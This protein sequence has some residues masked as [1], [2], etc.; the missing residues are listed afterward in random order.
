[1]RKKELEVLLSNVDGFINPK[2]KFEQYLTSSSIVADIIWDAYQKGYIEGKVVADLGC[3]SGI[4][5]F[6]ALLLGAKKVFFV[7][8]DPDAIIIAKRNKIFL[9][10]KLKKNFSCD[11]FCCSVQE[12]KKNVDVVFQNPPFGTKDMHA[13]RVFLEKALTVAPLVYSFHK[14]STK[15]F[16]EVFAEDNGFHVLEVYRY[17]F[18]IKA[19]FSFHRSRVKDV[20]VGCWCLQKN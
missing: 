7:D 11:F 12:F 15:K 4:F 14:Y 13:D 8:I 17:K 19:Q 3:G 1:M 20:D 10:N 5:G 2:V 18:P 16:V 9:E 6:G